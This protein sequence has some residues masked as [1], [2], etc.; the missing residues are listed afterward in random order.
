[1]NIIKS[2]T[3]ISHFGGV[4]PILKFLK[5][6]KIPELIRDCLGTRVKQAKYSYEDVLISWMLT[7]YCGGY[8]LDHITSK[9]KHLSII[10]G[11][12]LPSHDTLGRVLKKLAN[13][14][15]LDFAKNSTDRDKKFDTT[16]NGQQININEPMNNLLLQ[17]TVQ[18][19]LIN[20][21]ET[22]TLDLD[23]TVVPNECFDAKMSYKR[24][25]AYAPMI[26][27]IGQLPIFIEN[28]N[29]NVAPLS[30]ILENVKTSIDRLE[31]Q[32]IKIDKVRMDSGGYALD[33]MEYMDR[34]G[35][36]FYIGAKRSAGMMN[37]IG[38]HK[39]WRRIEFETTQWVWKCQ[40]ADVPF[41]MVHGDVDHR[42][43]VLRTKIKKKKK[44]PAKWLEYEGY[45]YRVII[46]NDHEG[47][48]EEIVHFHNARGAVERSY[49][50]LK[51][52]FGFRLPPFSNMNENTVFMLLSALTNNVYHALVRWVSTEFEE[53]S[54]VS[55]L[56][57]FI[58]KFVEVSLTFV[59]KT[60]VFFTVE[61]PYEKFC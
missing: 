32:N 45:A 55:R 28:R 8:R 16:V 15:S 7:N 36:K 38:K 11:L 22:H 47:V 35:V 33:A 48:A 46:T 37:V 54:P 24:T 56:R 49:D 27:S 31:E 6:F 41:R 30:R 57:E 34:K 23:V 52:C 10:P 18:L 14:I 3:K 5:S 61:R 9:S 1:M 17:T 42:L 21:G 43:V 29:G 39:K 58:Q 53:L 44:A 12:K 51:N 60:P 20:P 59:N 25:R 19:G 2:N 13:D 26:A 4:L 50:V 40:I